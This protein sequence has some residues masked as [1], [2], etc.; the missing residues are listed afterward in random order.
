V[1]G[2]EPEKIAYLRLLAQSGLGDLSIKGL[3]GE[4]LNTFKVK[5]SP[6]RHFFLQQKVKV[7]P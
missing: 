6:H 2:F 3:V 1:M 4:K 5:F 7:N